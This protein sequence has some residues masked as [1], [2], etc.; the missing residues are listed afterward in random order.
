M[1]IARQI[2]VKVCALD[3]ERARERTKEKVY[4]R[5]MLPDVLTVLM[6]IMALGQ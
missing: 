2:S 6:L 3:K 5:I 1:Y 4:I